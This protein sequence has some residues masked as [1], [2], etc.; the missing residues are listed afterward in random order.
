MDTDYTILVTLTYIMI[1]IG[2]VA[3]IGLIVAFFRNLGKIESKDKL[4]EE[5]LDD[6]FLKLCK[7]L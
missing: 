6:W 4:E 2:G 3:G 5:K 7:K 1:I